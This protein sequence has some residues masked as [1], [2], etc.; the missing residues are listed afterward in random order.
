MPC[1][2]V[3]QE[4]I[5]KMLKRLI[6]HFGIPHII[7]SDNGLAFTKAKLSEFVIEYR[8]YWLFYSNYYPQGNRLAK[9]TNKNLSWIIKRTIEGNPR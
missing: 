1:K 6:T 8:I 5:I 3:D 4:I 2:S 9:S 7:L